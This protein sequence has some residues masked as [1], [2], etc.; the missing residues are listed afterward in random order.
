MSIF[1][2]LVRVANERREAEL[3][4]TKAKEE[5]EQ[6]ITQERL[7]LKGLEEE[8]AGLREEVLA[9]LTKNDEVNVVV[10]NMSITRQTRKTLKITDPTLLLASMSA[11]TNSLIELGI[12]VSEIHKAFKHELVVM[13]KKLVMDVIEKYFLVEGKLLEGA[14]EQK[15]NFLVIKENK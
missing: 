2:D 14:E 7:T 15:T 3:V 9:T 8:E 10:D 5:F 4:V 6:T 12:D 11:E 13:N 1:Q